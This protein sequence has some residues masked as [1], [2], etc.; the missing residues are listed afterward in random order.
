MH[1]TKN[2][3]THKRTMFTYCF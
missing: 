3:L 1:A 2:A